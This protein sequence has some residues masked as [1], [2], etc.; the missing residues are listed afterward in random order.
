LARE[1]RRL[2]ARVTRPQR[3]ASE[4][5]GLAELSGRER[6]I[7]ELVAAGRRNQ[8]IAEA[9]FLSVRTVEGHLGRVYRKLDVSSR[10]QLA[11]LVNDPG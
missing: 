9:L 5:D 1:L 4:R 6:E 2:G 11:T 3:A 10:T 8:E 7:A